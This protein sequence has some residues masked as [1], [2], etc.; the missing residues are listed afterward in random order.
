[1][2]QII[3]A[4]IHSA[5]VGMGGYQE[6]MVS[7][8]IVANFGGSMSGMVEGHHSLYL[9]PSYTHHSILTPF[10]HI[11]YLWLEATGAKSVADM[12]GKTVRLEMEDVGAGASCIPI[13]V[14]HIV[15][16]DKWF[17]TDEICK[18]WSKGDSK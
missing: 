14:G 2:S 18:A 13:R 11:V 7:L 15:D 6:T 9:P 4:K 8:D 17:S 5:S 1:M 10:A 3:N 12:V 16:D